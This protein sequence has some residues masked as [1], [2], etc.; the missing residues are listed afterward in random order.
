MLIHQTRYR[1]CAASRYTRIYD[2]DIPNGIRTVRRTAR[3]RPKI[4]VLV[5]TWRNDGSFPEVTDLEALFSDIGHSIYT[6]SISVWIKIN[7]SIKPGIKPRHTI[8]DFL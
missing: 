5:T 2:L 4:Y 1:D 7:V 6:H 8:S 3:T